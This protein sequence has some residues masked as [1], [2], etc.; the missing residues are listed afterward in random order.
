[1]SKQLEMRNFASQSPKPYHNGSLLYHRM[2][3]RNR[4]L[5]YNRRLPPNT[6]LGYSIVIVIPLEGSHIQLQALGPAIPGA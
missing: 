4:Q 6:W 1:M 3:R 5:A 2:N